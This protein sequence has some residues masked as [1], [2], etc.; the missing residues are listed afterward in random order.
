MIPKLEFVY[1]YPKSHY[2]WI[3]D[4]PKFADVAKMTLEEVT[5]VVFAASLTV[6]SKIQ[7]HAERIFELLAELSGYEW[8]EHK[9]KVY[10]TFLGP[11]YSDPLS[12][13]VTEMKQGKLVPAPIGQA[14]GVLIHELAHNIMPMKLFADQATAE[15]IM[16]MVTFRILAELGFDSYE[17]R[18][19]TD[20][21]TKDQLR[22]TPGSIKE[23]DLLNP[24]VREY[25]KNIRSIDEGALD[26]V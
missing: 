19:F 22:Y 9:I 6:E 1:L 24:T 16:D 13:R 3:K 15:E 10:P 23:K 5:D 21:I 18:V 8:Q 25:L 4:N 17:Y 14:S 12:L 26:R 20:T 2:L 11:S 7:P